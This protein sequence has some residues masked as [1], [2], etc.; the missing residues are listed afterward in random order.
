MEKKCME[1]KEN[2]KIEKTENRN[3]RKYME[4]RFE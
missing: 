3:I 1:I 4:K 2:K